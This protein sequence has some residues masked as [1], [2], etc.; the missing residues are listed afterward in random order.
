MQRMMTVVIADLHLMTEI[1]FFKQ[2]EVKLK[3]K[4]QIYVILLAF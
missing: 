3:I 1:P 2:L 4:V